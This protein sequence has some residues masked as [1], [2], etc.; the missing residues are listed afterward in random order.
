MS[1]VQ[2]VKDATDIIQVIGERITLKRSGINYKAACPFHSEK[3]ASFF[4]SESLQRFKCFGCGES[5]DVITFLEKYEGMTFV[6]ALEY[7][8]DQAGITLTKVARSKQD[9]ERDQLL[10][11]LDLAKEYY[12]YLLTKHDAGADART[13][14]KHRG[15]SSESIKIFQMGYALPGWDGLLKYLSKKKKYSPELLDKAGLVVKGRGGRYYDRF[16]GRIIFPLKNH[17]GQVVGFSGRVLDPDVK[18]AKYIN[19]PETALYHKSKMLYGYSELL[20]EIRKKDRVLVVEGELDVISSAQAHV[21]NIVALKGS[22]L[23]QEQL[24]LLNRV[25]QTVVLA[26]DTDSAGV[27]ATKRAVEV[28]RPMGVDLRVLM[29][30]S[31]KDPDELAS[32]KPDQWRKAAAKT[33]SVY[34]FFITTA[35][36]EHDPA[37]PE[38]RRNILKEVGPLIAGITHAVERDYYVTKLAEALKVRE[39]VVREDIARIGSQRKIGAK[40]AKAQQASKPKPA[41]QSPREKLERHVLTLLLTSSSTELSKRVEQATELTYVNDGFGSLFEQLKQRVAA[42][43]TAGVAA[44]VKQLADD[45]QQLVFD[46]MAEQDFTETEA[47]Q[48]ANAEWRASIKRLQQLIAKEKVVEITSKLHS[49]D[50]KDSLTEA[51][52]LQQQQLLREVVALRSQAS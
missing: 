5:G 11:V 6:E 45:Q 35:L 7:L 24:K 28:A 23:T 52:E 41:T 46:I 43:P 49:L 8:A 36:A 38:G 47:P 3:T 20:Q 26:L 25:T 21:N 34:D 4:V 27:E 16:R 50:Q 40:S 14:L 39:A 10:A 33:V 15:V 30:P 32:S 1:Q 29:L 19:S 31:G 48:D 17:R 22:A 42:H 2:Q 12:H 44:T 18:E 13:Y 9:D 37:S 51:E